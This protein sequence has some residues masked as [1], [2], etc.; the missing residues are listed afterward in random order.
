MKRRTYNT[1]LHGGQHEH[2]PTSLLEAYKRDPDLSSWTELSSWIR[3]DPGLPGIYRLDPAPAPGLWNAKF[4][5][6]HWLP[7]VLVRAEIV[8]AIH[9]E[10][11]A[12]AASAWP[13]GR[14]TEC[15]GCAT[16]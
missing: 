3:R 12:V 1:R 16:A 9:G 15:P 11:R 7:D 10:R 14:L 4:G 8:R 6:S 13:H 5:S 2:P